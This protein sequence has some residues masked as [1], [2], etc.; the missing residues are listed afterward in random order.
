MKIKRVLIIALAILMLL[1]V[2]TFA[3]DGDGWSIGL[4][5]DDYDVLTQEG[6]TLF[7]RTS[8]DNIVVQKIEQKVFGGKLTQ[9]QLNSISKEVTGQY[10]Q[11]YNA[12]V[13]E[14]GRDEITVNGQNVTRMKFKTQVKTEEQEIAIYQEMNIFVTENNL[15]DVIFTTFTEDGFSD[16][17]KTTILNS[18][19][20]AGVDNNVDNTNKASNTEKGDNDVL[21]QI[22]T[23]V[24]LAVAIVVIVVVTVI[25]SKKNKKAKAEVTDNPIKEDNEEK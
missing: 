10:Q 5:E 12:T 9:Y 15:F 17:E 21:F 18:F 13:E 19:K 20:I 2:S 25:K 1:S 24:L 8:G 22:L 4:S 16:T 23:L 7:Q 11:L 6:I 14:L 3:Y